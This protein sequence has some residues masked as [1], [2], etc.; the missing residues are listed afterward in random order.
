MT[1][2]RKVKV[3]AVK[4]D[5]K[6][7]PIVFT[8]NIKNEYI[9]EELKAVQNKTKE[10]EQRIKQQI[11]KIKA[12]TKN[13]L[14]KLQADINETNEKI[15]K[16]FSKEIDAVVKKL[17]ASVRS[18]SSQRGLGAKLGYATVSATAAVRKPPA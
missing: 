7:K 15:R 6:D 16:A 1:K 9:R 10:F 13:P 2:K 12:N 11:G 14:A 17:V 8:G 5:A 3:I 4:S 18:R